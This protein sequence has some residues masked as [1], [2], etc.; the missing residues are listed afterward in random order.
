ME[1]RVAGQPRAR[2]H[3]STRGR[4]RY[5]CADRPLR[6]R[7]LCRLRRHP[8]E[9]VHGDPA[10]EWLGRRLRRRGAGRLVARR[11]ERLPLRVRGQ[12]AGRTLPDLH[13]ERRLRAGVDGGWAPARGRLHGHHAD[14]ARDHPRQPR[15][16]VAR[17]VRTCDRGERLDRGLDLRSLD[18]RCGRRPALGPA[19]WNRRCQDERKS[20]VATAGSLRA[21]PDRRAGRRRFDLPNRSR[22]VAPHRSHGR[23]LRH[24]PP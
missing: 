3:L 12:P 10:H 9:H 11:P 24:F 16:H 19:N 7:A 2:L 23:L 5:H 13:R 4:R 6:R 20:P 22:P 17:S 14:S 1:R 21:G 15:E 18:D 8:A